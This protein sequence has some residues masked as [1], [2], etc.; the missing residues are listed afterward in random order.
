M[1]SRKDDLVELPGL[2]QF[3]RS[4]LFG[5]GKPVYIGEIM[6]TLGPCYTVFQDWQ[7][8]LDTESLIALIPRAQ[9]AAQQMEALKLRATEAVI[10]IF[11]DSDSAP[12]NPDEF[13]ASLEFSSETIIVHMIDLLGRFEEGY[14]PA[15]HFNS[16][17]E[18]INVS[19]EC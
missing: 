10:S 9:L 14:W 1:N 2:G 16:H 17:F 3:R 19:L 5:T 12:V 4:E 6:T 11:A 15:V 18:V 13:D 7:R 8:F